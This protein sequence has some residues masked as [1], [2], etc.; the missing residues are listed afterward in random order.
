MAALLASSREDF[1]KQVRR[2][3]QF[4]R[5]KS[6]YRGVTRRSAAGRWEARI[7]GI[8]GKKYTYLGTFDTAEEAAMAYDRA[9]IAHKGKD[10]LTNFDLSRYEPEMGIIA[11]MRKN[12]LQGSVDGE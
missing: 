5:G 10:A 8:F 12:Q 7:S 1:V 9:A 3:N 6:K 11:Q 4:A 2:D